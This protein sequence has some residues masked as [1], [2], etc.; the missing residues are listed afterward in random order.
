M[1]N[2]H[3][4]NNAILE[5]EL[6]KIPFFENL[7]IKNPNHCFTRKY[8]NE[9]MCSKSDTFIVSKRQLNKEHEVVK[10]F[11]RLE[12]NTKNNR[13]ILVGQTNVYNSMSSSV[14][15]E[16]I[17]EATRN[18][19]P[20]LGVLN[21]DGDNDQCDSNNSETYNDDIVIFERGD[22]KC[23]KNCVENKRWNTESNSVKVQKMFNI[24]GICTLL[25][26]MTWLFVQ[27]KATNIFLNYFKIKEKR[28]PRNYEVSLLF[29]KNVFQIIF[30]AVNT[31]RN[32]W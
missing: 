8:R 29:I 10:D 15:T 6:K 11:P 27:L 17:N 4:K 22:Y 9:E 24:L 28:Q 16:Y 26:L 21:G 13:E 3:T 18:S 32:F 12:H 25:L 19:K 14:N 30:S 1:K 5:E 31:V 7:L 20:S 23:P 2:L